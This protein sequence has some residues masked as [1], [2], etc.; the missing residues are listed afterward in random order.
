MEFTL[1]LEFTFS[2]Q[3]NL[4]M[5]NEYTVREANRIEETS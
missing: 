1:T 3:R 4:K 2:S 5:V